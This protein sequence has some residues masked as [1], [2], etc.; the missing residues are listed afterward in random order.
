LSHYSHLI[1][2]KAATHFR[3]QEQGKMKQSDLGTQQNPRRN[4]SITHLWLC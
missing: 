1:S 4:A 2:Q 3:P